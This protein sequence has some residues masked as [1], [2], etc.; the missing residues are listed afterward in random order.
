MAALE[1]LVG[2][3]ASPVLEARLRRIPHLVEACAAVPPDTEDPHWAALLDAVTVQETRLF[4]HPVQCAAVAHHLPAALAR[5]RAE[6]RPFRLLS[7]GCATGEEAFTLAALAL[8]ATHGAPGIEIE[9]LGLDLCR[10]ALASAEAGIIAPGLG[11]PLGLVPAD[12]RRWFLD[13]AGQTRLHPSLRRVLRFERR[14]LLGL[15]ETGFDVVFCRNVLIYLT[16]PA[17]RAVTEA[18]CAALQP[19]GLLALGPTDRTPPSAIA[20]GESLWSMPDV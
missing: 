6:G 16:E 1:S 8:E 17:R 19:G 11:D 2:F 18:L 13:A 20:C 15:S 5:A 4:R 14:N 10:P 12:L 3:A 9:V 7:A